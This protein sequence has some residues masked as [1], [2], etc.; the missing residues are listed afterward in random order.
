MEKDMEKTDIITVSN[1]KSPI[2]EAFRTL[3][4]NIQF[5][6]FD[7]SVQ[8]VSITSSGPGEGKSTIASNLAVVTA[9]SGKK[10]LLIDCDQRKP[11]I[12]KI[13]NQ[14]NL[15]GLSNLLAGEVTIENAIKPTAI[16]NLSIMTAGTRPPNPSELLAS[17]KMKHFI[18]DMKEKYDFIVI[19]TPPV[20]I[21]TDAQ[22]LADYTDG[23]LLVVSSGAAEKNAAMKAKELLEN[24]NAKILG[25]V[26]NNIDVN[27]SSYYGYYYQYYYAEQPLKTKRKK[28]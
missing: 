4:T 16:E 9:E 23:Y 28:K 6:S 14:S 21:V 10:T 19:D 11:M 25:V 27:E 24:V 18:E 20:L 1:P 12:H 15:V 3:R 7:K 17:A 8:T 26:L 22:L 5:S 13:F 2:A